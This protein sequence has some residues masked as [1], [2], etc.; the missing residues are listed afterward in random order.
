MRG[1][2]YGLALGAAVVLAAGKAAAWGPDAHRVIAELADRILVQNDAAAAAK[3]AEIVATDREGKGPAPTVGDEA[4]WPDKLRERS[5]EARTATA[6]WHLVPL[7]FDHP[8]LTRDCFGRQPLPPGYPASHGPQ[9]NCAVDKIGQFSV[10]LMNRETSPGERLLAVRY[11]L[12]L[13]GDLHD[14]LHAIDRGDDGGRCVAVAVGEMKTPVRLVD[15]WERILAREVIG[16]DPARAALQIGAGIGGEE[17]RAWAE[18]DAAAWAMD[19][20]AVARTIVYSFLS[21][22][23]AGKYTFPAAKGGAD[24]CG[25]VPLYRLGSDYETKGL[26]AVK[27]QLAKGAV[28]L[29]L[30]LRNSLQ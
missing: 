11:L 24:S 23:P 5:P 28:R 27:T 17:A 25:A 2:L 14:P 29:A 30:V 21:E 26:I 3:L 4:D 16:R 7:K 18:G 1:W 12:N 22:A 9:D 19:S 15:Y 6:L 20:Y 13:V 8:D 10:E